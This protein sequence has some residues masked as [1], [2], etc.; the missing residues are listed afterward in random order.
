MQVKMPRKK[1][2]RQQWLSTAV[3][4][5]WRFFLNGQYRSQDYFIGRSKTDA[6]MVSVWIQ[7]NGWQEKAR[8]SVIEKF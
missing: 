7:M 2:L 5:S 8:L 4:P 1:N 6:D 3:R